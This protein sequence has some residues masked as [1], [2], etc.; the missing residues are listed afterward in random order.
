VCFSL[1]QIIKKKENKK[2]YNYNTNHIYKSANHQKAN[3]FLKLCNNTNDAANRKT[4][5]CKISEGNIYNVLETFNDTN[6]FKGSHAR[7]VL[8]QKGDEYVL[9]CM[10]TDFSSPKDIATN[11]SMVFGR[12]P[13]QFKQ[14]ENF[15]KE[16]MNKHNISP[17]KLTVIGNSEGGAEALFLKAKLQLKEA[18]TY[19]TYFPKL[20]GYNQYDLN[21]GV[22]NYRTPG[23]IVSKA[24]PSYGQDFIVD[25]KPDIIAPKGPG[26]IPTYH[27]IINMGDCTQAQTPDIYKILHPGFKNKIFDGILKS[28]E[29]EAIPS[30]MYSLFDETITEMLKQGLVIKEPAPPEGY[31][32]IGEAISSSF[33]TP[34]SRSVNNY[35]TREGCA[36]TYPV[37]GYTRADG[38]EVSGYTRTCGAKHLH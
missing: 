7:A 16:Q 6:F 3:D 8:F 11:A 29:I 15:A 20:K 2:M 30:E 12:E 37:S 21:N 18:Y 1:L 28:Y 34:I 14:I 9:S 17:N 13:R 10:G 23:D 26:S 31:S 19:N 35:M 33:A 27:R 24:S 36:G 38:T 5:K 22:Y 4:K 32:P 25:L